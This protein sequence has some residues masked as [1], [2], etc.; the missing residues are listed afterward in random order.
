[1]IGD[2]ILTASLQFTKAGVAYTGDFNESISAR[3]LSTKG[4]NAER[5]TQIVTNVDGTLPLGSIGTVGY[6]HLINDGPSLIDTPGTP[7]IVNIGTPGATTYTYKIVGKQTSPTTGSTVASGAGSTATGNATLDVTN[8]N[9]VLWLPV[10][11]AASYDVYRTV[12]GPTQGKIANV[13]STATTYTDP[14][15]G[16]VYMMLEDQGLAGDGVTAPATT[17]YDSAVTFGPDGIIYPLILKGQ[18]I[19][20]FK[21]N[22]AAIHHKSSANTVPIRYVLIEA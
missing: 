5:G 17:P 14:A 22:A 1:M 9:R 6:V 20:M 10:D 4:K 21:W 19:A 18:E 15:T 11:N 8:Y 2:L 3:Q 7:T 16:I 13:L 12:G